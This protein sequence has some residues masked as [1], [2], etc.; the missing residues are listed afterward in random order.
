MTKFNRFGNMMPPEEVAERP[1]LQIA[2]PFKI[3][4]DLFYVGNVFCSSLLIN[5]GEGLALLDTPPIDQLPYLIDSI[6]QLGHDIREIKHIILSHAHVD[7]YGSVAALVSITGALTYMG[8]LDVADMRNR[9]EW[10]AD[11]NKFGKGFNE[12]FDADVELKDG[13]ILELGNKKIRCV[14][15]PG[16]TI[17]TMSHFWEEQENGNKYRLGIYGGAGFVTLS[18]K[19]AVKGVDLDETK[20]IF[21][22]SID[23]VW[24]EK[25]DIMLGNHPFHNDLLMKRSRELSGERDVYYNPEEWRTFL[26]ELK[27]QFDVFCELSEVEIESM[28]KESNY[29]I[30]RS[31]WDRDIS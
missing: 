22:K 5:T 1:Y 9:P 26:Q 24:D 19:F 3:I 14:L 10:F 8:E 2:K 16:H 17:G 4:G 20:R 28:Y 29:G 7:H 31:T 15:T 18:P 21:R 11:H 27:D 23:K 12:S 13:E 25:V 6:W 30:Y